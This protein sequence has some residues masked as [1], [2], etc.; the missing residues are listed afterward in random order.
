M[1]EYTLDPLYS[2]AQR[3]H[4]LDKI[5]HET[6]GPTL[7]LPE[8]HCKSVQHRISLLLKRKQGLTSANNLPLKS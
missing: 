8:S 4:H 6:E 3:S 2:P 7:A 1:K 5:C